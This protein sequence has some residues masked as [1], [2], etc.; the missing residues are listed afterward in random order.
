MSQE[1]GRGSSAPLHCS[2]KMSGGYECWT[3]I[4][5]SLGKDEP[6]C[7]SPLQRP[8]ELSSRGDTHGVPHS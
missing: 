3:D 7:L 4:L 2:P 5:S 8:G 6:F 1:R